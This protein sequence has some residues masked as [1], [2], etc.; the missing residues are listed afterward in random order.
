[1]SFCY[2]KPSG[3]G[4][5]V[6]AAAEVH[7][8]PATPPKTALSSQPSSLQTRESLGNFP[9]RQDAKGIEVE[10]GGPGSCS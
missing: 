1:M 9:Q 6:T 3:L 7:A 8:V 4:L 10:V 5:F 2:S